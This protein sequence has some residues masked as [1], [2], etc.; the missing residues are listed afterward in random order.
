M[1]TLR[2]LTPSWNEEHRASAVFLPG[3]RGAFEVLPGHAPIISTLSAGEIR[4]RPSG[5]GPEILGST[6]EDDTIETIVDKFKVLKIRSGIM[7]LE[8]NVMTVC[9]E[10]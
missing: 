2:I 3:T 8:Q 10:V 1:I 5:S 7:R 6:H 4:W 9:C